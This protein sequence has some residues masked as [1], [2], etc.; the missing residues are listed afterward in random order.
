MNRLEREEANRLLLA[1][2]DKLNQQIKEKAISTVKLE[3]VLFKVDQFLDEYEWEKTRDVTNN[4]NLDM[5]L[6]RARDNLQENI[7]DDPDLKQDIF[8]EF[9]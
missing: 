4:A 1:Y 5:T 3:L 7:D 9:L 6:E 2:Q 8:Q